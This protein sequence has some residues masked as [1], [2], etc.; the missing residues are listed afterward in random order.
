MHINDNFDQYFC[1]V[2]YKMPFCAFSSVCI[3]IFLR[4]RY[5]FHIFSLS[6]SK[7]R[8]VVLHMYVCF[9]TSV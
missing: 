4:C 7:C 6:I 1:V 9:L 5:K 2:K 3:H 8:E